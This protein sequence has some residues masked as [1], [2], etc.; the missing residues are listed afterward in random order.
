MNGAR[1]WLR[2]GVRL[3]GSSVMAWL[4]LAVEA[5]RLDLEPSVLRRDLDLGDPRKLTASRADLLA[6]IRVVNAYHEE[7]FDSIS[8]ECRCAKT[9]KSRLKRAIKELGKE[10]DLLSVC[11]CFHQAPHYE[12]LEYAATG[13]LQH[14][15]ERPIFIYYQIY[16]RAEGDIDSVKDRDYE[17]LDR[18]SERG[19]KGEGS[20]RRDRD[21]PVFQSG[22]DCSRLSPGHAAGHDPCRC[23][24]P[25]PCR[26]KCGVKWKNSARRWSRCLRL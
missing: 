2:E 3:A 20:P 23:P 21:Q 14:C 4:R 11:E 24:Y 26:R 13:A 22:R 8:L 5:E 12:L 1:Q 6:L 7:G 17:C 10:E 25:C 18:C 15:P 19:H 9:W 16:G